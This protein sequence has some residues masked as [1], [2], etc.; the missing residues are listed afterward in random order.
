MLTSYSGDRWPASP[1]LMARSNHLNSVI[2]SGMAECTLPAAYGDKLVSAWV[3]QDV[4]QL[5][6][7]EL[8]GTI[9][10]FPP[11][12]RMKKALSASGLRL[13]GVRVCHRSGL[14]GS[15]SRMQ[16]VRTFLR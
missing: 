3:E 10:V 1:S 2:L 12:T 6:L 8:I 16:N 15:C 9:Q 13:Q 4:S 5:S 14:S 11:N 7:E